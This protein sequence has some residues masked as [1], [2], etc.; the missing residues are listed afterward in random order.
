MPDIFYLVVNGE[1]EE[2]F[3]TLF[4]QNGPP[5]AGGKTSENDEVEMDR[6]LQSSYYM[7][8]RDAAEG[9]LTD[10]GVST[11]LVNLGGLGNYLHES[12]IPPELQTAALRMEKGDLLH[13][14]ADRCDIPW[15]LIKNGGEFW[16]QM[17]ILSNSVMREKGRKEPK[18]L[19]VEVKKVLNVIGDGIDTFAADRA[20]QLFQNLGGMVD[21]QLIDGGTDPEATFKVY[22]QLPT[23]DIVHFTSHGELGTAGAYLRIGKQ[24]G[25][26]ANFMVT[27]IKQ[28]SLRDDCIVF[29]NACVSAGTEEVIGRPLGFGPIF[30]QYG[31]SAFIGTLDFVP[32]KS[33]VLFAEYFYSLLFSGCEVGKALWTAKQFPSKDK[34]T[35]G[36]VPLLY[37][38]YG[39]PFSAVKLQSGK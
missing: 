18:P 37:S 23:A 6:F 21:V 26:F 13:V 5:L 35:M 28:G 15:E 33:A 4:P 11:Y 38:L 12:A 2:R 8:L 24:K 32:S 7:A 36:L 39:N 27:S 19:T 31:A 17:F 9:N 16:G 1:R 30:C 3:Y 34:G 25:K 20:R 10:S 14:F 22:E 29:A